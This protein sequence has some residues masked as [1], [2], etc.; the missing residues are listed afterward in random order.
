MTAKW[1]EG[2]PHELMYWRKLLSGR[3]GAEGATLLRDRLNPA[4]PLHPDV[5]AALG[6]PAGTTIRALDIGAGPLSSLGYRSE[7]YDVVLTPI[8]ALADDYTVLLREH[9]M[10]P[11]VPTRKMAAEQIAVV[12]RPASFELVHARNSLD[13]CA[14]PLR[15]L[16]A[17]R[18]LLVPGGL[19]YIRTYFNEG[20]RRQYQGLHGWNFEV[21]DD[22]LCLWRPGERHDLSALF[23][24]GRLRTVPEPEVVFAYTKG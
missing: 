14:D 11:P 21:I 18:D 2:L 1:A 15:V 10:T 16:L 19:L 13:H 3:K 5:E 22:R 17:A 24:G 6:F 4:N 9:G 12:F 23:L 7:R 8:D 20:E